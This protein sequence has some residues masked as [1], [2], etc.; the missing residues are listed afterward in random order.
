MGLTR[1]D[2]EE[3]VYEIAPVGIS[4]KEPPLQMVPLFTV[5]LGLLPTFTVLTVPALLIQPNAFVPVTV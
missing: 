3:Y 2:P 1:D 4:V 5:I